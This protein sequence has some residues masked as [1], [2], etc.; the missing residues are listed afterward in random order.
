M[1]RSPDGFTMIEMVIAILIGSI[2]T[3]IAL[4]GL[5]NAQAGYAVRG[6]KTTYEALHARARA[7]AIE[8]GENVM[9]HLDEAGDS[10]W[11]AHAG[12]V[13]ETIHFDDN[14]NV[15][16]EMTGTGAT[17]MKLCF[18]PRGYADLNCST[19]SGMFVLVFRRGTDQESII[20]LPSG[21]ILQTT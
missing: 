8:R 3:S 5:S 1:S 6:A 20:L 4:T 19:P 16:V 10:A 11:I 14:W 2:L 15:D 13:L 18:T 21:Q 17:S 12:D 7:H 9:L